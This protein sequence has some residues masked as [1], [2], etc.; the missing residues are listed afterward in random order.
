MWEA[1]AILSS[2]VHFDTK[3]TLLETLKVSIM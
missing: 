2:G 3:Q 1:M